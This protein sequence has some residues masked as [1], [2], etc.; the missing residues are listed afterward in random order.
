MSIRW[1]LILGAVSFLAILLAVYVATAMVTRSQKGD[2]RVINLAGRQRAVAAEMT[3]E[4]MAYSRR[5]LDERWA[6]FEN[7]S[8]VFELTQTALLDG[9]DAPSTMKADG[10]TTRLEEATDTQVRDQLGS[11]TI[12]LMNFQTVAAK[13]KNEA[14]AARESGDGVLRQVPQ[15]IN[16]MDAVVTRIQ[17]VSEDESLSA[18]ERAEWGALLAYA[19]RQR[20][21]IQKLGTLAL[22]YLRNPDEQR[23][24]ALH[25]SISF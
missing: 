13:I 7:T 4:L 17:R 9:G 5:P 25:E 11:V 18:D 3:G 14:V 20:L 2:G 21:L 23:M 16:R 8:L 15:L 22:S 12:S 24:E 1:K 19:A 10:P 6:T